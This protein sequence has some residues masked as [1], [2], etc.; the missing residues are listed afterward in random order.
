MKVKSKKIRRKM[1]EKS[2]KLYATGDWKKR[3]QAKRLM[4]KANKNGWVFH[5]TRNWVNG[6]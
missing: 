6:I 1:R 3:A 5:K 2:L 4:E